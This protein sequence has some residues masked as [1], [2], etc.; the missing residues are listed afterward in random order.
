M[1]RFSNCN[2][3]FWENDGGISEVGGGF[4]GEWR[5]L[6]GVVGIV[7]KN[8]LKKRTLSIGQGFYFLV[9]VILNTLI[10]INHFFYQSVANDVFV[11]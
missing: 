9:I 11:I 4:L 5:R 3:S 10:C 8:L 6:L 2:D 1:I 7:L